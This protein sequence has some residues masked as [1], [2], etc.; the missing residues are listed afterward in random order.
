[1]PTTLPRTERL[2]RV[3]LSFHD[4]LSP[5]VARSVRENGAVDT[6]QRLLGETDPGPGLAK[7][8]ARAQAASHQTWR[9][10]TGVTVLIPGDT[11]WP[12]ALEHL[13]DHAPHALFLRGQLRLERPIAV[14]GSRAC[15][16]QGEAT[17]T[18]FGAALSPERTVLTAAGWGI[19]AAAT[20]AAVDAGGAPVMVLACGIDRMYPQG[21]TPL[22]AAVEQAG[23]VLSEYPATTPPTRWRF[24]RQQRLVTALADEGLLIEAAHR[25]G[26]RDQAE[27]ILAAGKPLYAVPGAQPTP[28]SAGV[29]ALLDAGTAITVSTAADLPGAG[30]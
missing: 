5:A 23:A 14:I 6:V 22:A 11:L 7:D 10:P 4:T 20:R 3:L 15:T 12:A 28:V 8:R 26:S 18:A 21:L 25:S 2:A 1:M 9:V 17:A 19:S 13:S 24:T 30:E 29:T 27:S 16:L